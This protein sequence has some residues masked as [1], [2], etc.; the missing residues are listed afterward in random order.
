MRFSSL[1][2]RITSLLLIMI[3]VQAIFAQ[4]W[5]GWR[6]PKRD[7]V[8]T[9]FTTP[10]RWP[11]ALKT[12]WKVNVGVGHSSPLVAGNRVFLHARQDENEIV[13]AIDLMTGKTIW[14]NSYPAAYTMNPAARGH[15]KGPKS[16]PVYDNGR[17]YSLGITGILSCFDAAKGKLL[18]RKAFEERFK[19]NAP[20]FGTAMSPI[21]D[22][23]MLIV[24]AGGNDQGGMVAL[25]AVTG[26]E[27]WAWTGDGPG[28]ASPI[29]LEIAGKRTIVT[30]TQKLI[31]G[32]HADTG[33]LLWKIPFTTEFVQNI[34]TPVVYRDLLIFSGINKG[35]FAVRVGWRD[36]RW[37]TDQVWENREVSMYMNSPVLK[38]NLLFGMSHRNK[39]QF[40]C[41]DAATGKVLWTGDPRQGENAA[42]LLVNDYIFSLTNDAELIIT[43]V[44]DKGASVIRKYTVAQSPTWTH[45]VLTGNSIL[46]K[47][48]NTLALLGFE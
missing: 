8:V 25:D 12:R 1:P 48:E 42:M 2:G 24:H 45:P 47:D 40:F 28:Y 21:V 10:A 32:I 46:I 15:G 20:L 29:I 5:T 23:G 17:L 27:K 39:G 6:G 43:S 34:V 35:V 31:V 19:A 9:G 16:T 3:C 13:Y 7:G 44:A 37:V 22:R 18:W 33:G 38:G 4:D 36:N 14:R 30:Q 41:L 11:D 26:A